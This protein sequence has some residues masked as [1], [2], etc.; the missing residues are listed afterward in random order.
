[1]RIKNDSPQTKIRN[2]EI[3]E[4]TLITPELRSLKCGVLKVMIGM[5][6]NLKKKMKN[7]SVNSLPRTI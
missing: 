2:G 5:L 1:V 3:L 6:L 4:Y 7:H